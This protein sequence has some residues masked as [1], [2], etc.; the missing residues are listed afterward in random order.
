MRIKLSANSNVSLPAHLAGINVDYGYSIYHLNR[1]DDWQVKVASALD[2][3]FSLFKPLNSEQKEFINSVT[4]S[5]K[6]LDD[7]IP[8]E[9]SHL[10][11]FNIQL[12]IKTPLN[13]SIRKISNLLAKTTTGEIKYNFDHLFFTTDEHAGFMCSSKK[14][15]E[16]DKG[17]SRFEY[18]NTMLLGTEFF[19][20]KENH[21]SNCIKDDLG[22]TKMTNLL[23]YHE[24]SH[25]F[26]LTNVKQFGNKFAKIFDDINKNSNILAYNE[27][28]RAYLN[29]LIENHPNSGFNKIEPKYNHEIASLFKEIYA[30]VGA[31]LLQRNQDIVEGKHSKESDLT[32]INALISGRNNEDY[33]VKKNLNGF[34]YVSEFNHFTSP[35]LEYLK[36]NYESLPVKVLSQ[37][38]I[39][40]I[41][42]K[43]VEQGIS[44]VLIASSVAN[45]INRNE[46]ITLFSI[47]KET[48]ECIGG[49]REELNLYAKSDINLYNIRLE[50][51]S[52]YAGKDWIKNFYNNV[53]QIYSEKLPNPKKMVWN[54]AFHQEQFR[55]DLAM[56]PEASTEI[57]QVAPILDDQNKGFI[58]TKINNLV[59]RLRR[60]NKEYSNTFKHH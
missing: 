42:H 23:V 52:E 5:A 2:R 12:N 44:R 10:D 49:F 6:F 40:T 4:K 29:N 21:F 45:D 14:I 39:H 46:L 30:D 33:M 25:A 20:Q 9:D 34:E 16:T 55:K 32:N 56:P 7:S 59:D 53:N 41:A 58:A 11:D 18:R 26:E 48:K 43:A 13:D 3:I 60:P 47:Q 15:I 28:Q 50:E 19:N 51:L 38:E 27:V 35:G 22:L 8:V 54:A 24:A 36:E 17:E 37:E 31:V 1:D 57:N